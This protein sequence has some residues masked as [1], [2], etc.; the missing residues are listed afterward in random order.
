MKLE[1]DARVRVPSFEL[2]VQLVAETGVT[3]L[4]GPTASGK[5]LTLRLVAGLER[6]TAGCV[7][8]DG[9]R[10]DDLPP[11][12]RGLG[13]APQHAALWPHKTVLEHLTALVDASRAH[14][15]LGRVGLE[16]L[17]ARHPRNLS[18]GERQR[19]AFARAI[20]RSPTLL[21]LDEPFSALH[22]DAR[23][24]MGERVREEA[25][26]SVVL[27]VT[28]DRAEATRLGDGFVHYADGKARGGGPPVAPSGA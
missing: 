18:G 19:L 16:R 4:F 26:R 9:K 5:T 8:V 7:Q 6:A 24:E 3:V 27:F 17:A 2:D 14:A 10:L 15:V 11:H 13:Y 22:D 23:A 1:I 12:V 25:R 20:A 28:H 21:L